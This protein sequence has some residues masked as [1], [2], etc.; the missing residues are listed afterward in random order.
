MSPVV[1]RRASI[2]RLRGCRLRGDLSPKTVAQVKKVAA[3]GCAGSRGFYRSEAVPAEGAID[4]FG[5]PGPPY[6]LL[7]VSRGPSELRDSCVAA[8]SVAQPLP[9]FGM[10]ASTLDAAARN[11][12]SMFRFDEPKSTNVF[13]FVRPENT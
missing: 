8:C 10:A 7:Q 2:C 1:I 12:D 6:A 11:G 4:N 5:G 9:Q 13:R 3:E